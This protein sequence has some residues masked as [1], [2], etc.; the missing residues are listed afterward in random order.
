MF[1]V[2]NNDFYEC[3]ISNIHIEFLIVIILGLILTFIEDIDLIQNKFVL[4]IILLII[5]MMSFSNI[6]E[7][8]YIILLTILFVL[9]YNIMYKNKNNKKLE[10]TIA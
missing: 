6:N 4:I 10:Q 1:Q 3:I 7:L 8:G 5:L 9:V 2:Y